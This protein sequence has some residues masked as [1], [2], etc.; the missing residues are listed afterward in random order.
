[1][2]LDRR[3][4]SFL[5]SAALSRLAAVPLFAH[6][7][8]RERSPGGIRA[9]IADR[10]SSSLNT[11]NTFPGTISGGWTGGRTDVPIGFTSRSSRPTRTCAV[12]WSSTP[13]A[14][15]V[16]ARG[17]SQKSSMPAG[18]PARWVSRPAAGR[19]GRPVVRRQRSGA[20][21]PAQAE[22]G[23]LDLP[24]RS[25]RRGAAAGGNP[26]RPGPARTG[27]NDSAAGARLSLFRMCSSNRSCSAAAFST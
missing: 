15:W 17:A 14:R 20:Q 19:C 1:M 6:V 24:L 2:F 18:S 12:A 3:S 16:S 10:V 8:C 7:P 23:P 4:R 26:T 21:C 22:S 5:D 13:A 11:A 27:G 25:A 9:P